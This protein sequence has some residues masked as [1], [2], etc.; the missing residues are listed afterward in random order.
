MYVSGL[1]SILTLDTHISCTFSAE[2]SSQEVYGLSCV[3]RRLAATF[4]AHHFGSLEQSQLAL[5][6]TALSQLTVLCAQRS[7]QEEVCKRLFYS[8]ET[9]RYVH[10]HL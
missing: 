5:L 6:V 7:A 3:A 8:N 4:P 9:S 2:L 10:N 1:Q